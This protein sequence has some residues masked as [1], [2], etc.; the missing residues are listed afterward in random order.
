MSTEGFDEHLDLAKHAGEVTQEQ[1]D[2]YNQGKAPE[3]KAVRNIFKPANYAGVYGVRELTLSRSTGMSVAKCKDLLDA[4]W[5]R[6][7]SVNKIAK[8]Q[9]I[10]TLKDGSMYL[11]N[12]VSGFYYSLRYEKDTFSTLNQGTGVFVFDLWVMKCRDKGV[13]FSLQYHDEH[14]SYVPLGKE[15]EHK[16]LLEEA[17]REVNETLKLNVEITSDIQFGESY[18]AVH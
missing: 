15:E 8:A 16:K 4:Y 13:N 17:M 10:K 18:A 11:K 5:Q 14:L 7:W 2:L 9:F 12:P 3:L 1:I 6:N